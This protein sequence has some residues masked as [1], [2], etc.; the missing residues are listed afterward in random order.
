MNDPFDLAGRK[1]LVTGATRGIGLAIASALARRGA[2]VCITGRK[3][4]NLDAATR[5]V[6]A[7]RVRPC[8]RFSIVTAAAAVA[9]ARV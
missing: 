6:A 4:A 7:S 9:S 8:C 5:A 1:A 3:L 2:A